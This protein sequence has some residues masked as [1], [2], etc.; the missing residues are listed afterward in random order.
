MFPLE[1][2]QKR[3]CS[4]EIVGSTPEA[5]GGKERRAVLSKANSPEV[6][7][8]S[9]GIQLEDEFGGAVCN[10]GAEIIGHSFVASISLEDI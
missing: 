1:I 6:L 4:S 10:D 5:D 9:D 8:S 3:N 2:K 7:T